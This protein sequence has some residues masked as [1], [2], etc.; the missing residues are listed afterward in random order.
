MSD[1][2]TGTV[3]GSMRAKVS[4][5]AQDNGGQDVFCSLQ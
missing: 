4:F 2:A 3:N 1:K 5:I